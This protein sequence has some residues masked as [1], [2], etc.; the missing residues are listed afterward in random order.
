ACAPSGPGTRSETGID[1]GRIERMLARGDYTEAALA[2]EQ[3]ALSR[4]LD[5]DRLWLRA[6][7]AWLEAARLDQAEKTLRRID[8]AALVDA[9]L[10]RLDLVQ[11]ELAMRR[12][13]L[14]NAG[15]LLAS[16]AERLPRSLQARH[17]ELEA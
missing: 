16:T 4:P 8:T 12:G 13:D 7:E 2:F 3:Q 17:A 11:A 1:G 9:E 14:A 5:A 15:W 10:V 6:A